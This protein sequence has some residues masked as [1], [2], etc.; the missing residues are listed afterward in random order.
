MFLCMRVREWL[1]LPLLFS[2]LIVSGLHAQAG[3]GRS[4]KVA[5]ISVEGNQTADAN[6]IKLNSGLTSGATVTGEDIQKGIKQLWGL[7]LFSDIKSSSTKKSTM[8]FIS[9]LG[10]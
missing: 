4:I 10:S 6:F 9:Q 8:P 1:V 2:V 3:K 7:N 5:S